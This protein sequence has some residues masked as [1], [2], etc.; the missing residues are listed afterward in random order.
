[1][2]RTI[3]ALSAVLL[4]Y[5]PV[6]AEAGGVVSS[7]PGVQP[8]FEYLKS[9]RDDPQIIDWGFSSWAQGYIAGVN[10]LT[11]HSHKIPSMP[12]EISRFMRDY[13]AKHPTD[14]YGLGVIELF[15]RL[16]TEDQNDQWHLGAR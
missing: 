9:Y 7:G 6:N 13:C 14:P 4:A 1:M 11:N 2:T 15:D 8:C 12:D 3:I 10:A 16:P 5:V